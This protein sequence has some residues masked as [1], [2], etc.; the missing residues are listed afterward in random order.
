MKIN[1][2]KFT[3]TMSI[4]A[5]IAFLM[6]GIIFVIVDSSISNSVKAIVIALCPILGMAIMNLFKK[7][8]S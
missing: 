6:Y 8:G 5:L 7:P 2:I 4:I 1:T 3:I